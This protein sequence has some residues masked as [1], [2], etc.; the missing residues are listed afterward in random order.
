MFESVFFFVHRNARIG[1]A[2]AIV[3][4]AVGIASAVGWIT[5]PVG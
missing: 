3:M 5:A 1:I 4:A 2:V